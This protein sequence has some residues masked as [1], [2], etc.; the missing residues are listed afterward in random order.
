MGEGERRK[1]LEKQTE[2]A[3]FGAG[4]KSDGPLRRNRTTKPAPGASLVFHRQHA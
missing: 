4:A 1:A 3:S 2:A